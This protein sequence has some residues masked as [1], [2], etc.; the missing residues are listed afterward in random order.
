MW[1]ISLRAKTI[2]PV[3]FYF[4]KTCNTL[5]SQVKCLL[6]SWVWLFVIPWAVAC[7]APLSI[8][9]PGKNTGM[10]CHSLLQGIFLT[11]GSNLGLLHCRQ[12]P[13]GKSTSQLSFIAWMNN[14]MYALIQREQT[15]IPKSLF[16]LYSLSSRC[17]WF[18]SFKRYISSLIFTGCSTGK[19]HRYFSAYSWPL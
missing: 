4:L 5:T 12:E 18:S 1:L 7:Q 19:S 13:P 9:F 2:S 3:N 11:Q 17:I 10:G 14:K 8:G 16:S 15:F 6:L